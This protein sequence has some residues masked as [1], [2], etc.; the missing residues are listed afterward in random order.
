MGRRNGTRRIKI[1][2]RDMD[3]IPIVEWLQMLSDNK[4]KTSRGMGTNLTYKIYRRTYTVTHL[5]DQ[6]RYRGIYT[7]V[8][9]LSGHMCERKWTLGAIYASL[10]G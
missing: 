1:M 2:L 6:I 4:Y 7:G 10:S 5:E 3:A 9:Y 8:I